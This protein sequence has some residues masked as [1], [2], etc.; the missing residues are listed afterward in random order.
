MTFT[1]DSF[2]NIESLTVKG[3]VVG[4]YVQGTTGTAY[5]GQSYSPSVSAVLTPYTGPL[6]PPLTCSDGVVTEK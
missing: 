6:T 3:T 2:D 5:P 4:G 1:E